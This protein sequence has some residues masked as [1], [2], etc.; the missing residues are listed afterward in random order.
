MANFM[1]LIV[2][3]AYTIVMNKLINKFYGKYN[4]S[5]KR[6]KLSMSRNHLIEQSAF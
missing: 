4:N 3:K 5:K 2:E 6:E 1:D